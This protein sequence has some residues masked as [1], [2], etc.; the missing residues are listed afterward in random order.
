M[1]E[2]TKM[3]LPRIDIASTKAAMLL[4]AM[5]VMLGVVG[6]RAI[7]A[8]APRDNTCAMFR[9]PPEQRIADC[10]AI[11]KSAG[12]KAKVAE[13]YGHRGVAYF[14]EEK[15]DRTV[16]D[17]TAAIKLNAGT[18]VDIAGMYSIRANAESELGRLDA[19]I[20][21][22]SE[23]INRDAKNSDNW[24][25]RCRYRMIQGTALQAALSDCNAGIRLDTDND[26]GNYRVRG[27]VQ[28]KLKNFAAAIAD[29]NEALKREPGW[30]SDLYLR[31]IARRG[32]GDAAGAAAD[33][34]AA[35]AKDPDI[36]EGFVHWGLPKL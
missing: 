11:I 6:G 3:D 30:P 7:A 33:L 26:P 1:G 20:S 10:T 8:E 36:A 16:A 21:D 24:V 17:E 13:A 4:L 29:Y 23:A 9:A 31:A 14:L 28:I 27:V 32:A 5:I 19:A 25:E 12:S 2:I 15:Y 22:A 35:K 18:A 34:A